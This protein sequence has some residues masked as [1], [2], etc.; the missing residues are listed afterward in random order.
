VTH[1]HSDY[2]D[3]ISDQIN[4]HR[5]SLRESDSGSLK[6]APIVRSYFYWSALVTMATYLS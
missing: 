6:M 2:S 4:I 3:K 1:K 5:H